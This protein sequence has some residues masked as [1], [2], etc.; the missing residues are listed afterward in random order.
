MKISAI[1]L[2]KNSEK[3]IGDCLK[4]LSWVDEVLVV[5]SGSTDKTKK[6]TEAYKNAKFFVKR[7]G[8]SQKRNFGAKK[9]LG[10][11][12]LYID[13]DE[14]VS[15]ALQKEIESK[16]RISKSTLIGFAIPRKNILLGREMKY[17]GWWPDYVLR[18]IKKDA[19]VRWEGE[20]H[21]QPKVKGKVGKLKNPMIH[22]THRTLSEM[23][24]KTN[25][26]SEIEAKLLF[27]SGH[28]KMNLLRFMTA[29]WREFWYRGVKKMGF[30]DGAIGVIEIIYQTFS[31]MVTYTKLWEMQ[32][33]A[34]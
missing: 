25:E 30:L 14:R 13:S 26:W 27:K 22:I 21:E 19:L 5:D 20:L 8:F 17:G 12:L 24:E 18:L 23:V 1:V 31:R 4:S 15:S 10:E 9:A 11:W 34:K 3:M 29:G 32:V 16:I 2:T 7:N 33:R 6:I 28:P